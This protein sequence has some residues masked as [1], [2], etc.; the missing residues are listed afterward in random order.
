[1][2][3]K[4]Y[5]HALLAH[6][7]SFKGFVEIK[8]WKGQYA[9]TWDIHTLFTEPHIAQLFIPKQK[10]HRWLSNFF[11]LLKSHADTGLTFQGT[12]PRYGDAYGLP[13]KTCLQLQ[14]SFL[15]RWNQII[16]RYNKKTPR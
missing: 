9:I 3:T 10:H 6:N 1:M 13:H 15:T 4:T 2:K 14:K 12:Y 7:R 8:S 16:D 11:H 5:T